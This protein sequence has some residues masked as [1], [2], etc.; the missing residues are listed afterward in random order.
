[1]AS[2]VASFTGTTTAGSATQASQ[3]GDIFIACAF[4]DGSATPPATPAGWIHHS[5][6]AG[7]S[8]ALLLVYIVA[9]G[10]TTA[11]NG[12]FTN[13]ASLTI[14]QVRAGG[15]N[16]L[17]LGGFA[18]SAGV[19][20]ATSYPA[21]TSINGGV[22]SDYIAAA[23]HRSTNT[24]VNTAP[25]GM[26]NITSVVGASESAVHWTD[27]PIASWAGGAGPGGGTSSGWASCALELLEF[28]PT[29]SPITVDDSVLRVVETD[30]SVTT[31]SFTAPAG[32]LLVA[33][34]KADANDGL[35]TYNYSD[36][37]GLTW[38]EHVKQQAAGSGS[39]AIATAVTTSAV[40]RTV[41]VSRTGATTGDLAIK[42]FIV[43]GQDA[44]DPIGQTAQGA[45]AV[46]HIQP[47]LFTSGADDAYVFVAAT[48][49]QD[50]GAPASGDLEADNFNGATISFLTGYRYLGAIGAKGITLNA[51]STGTPDWDWAALE[52]LPSTGAAA[53]DIT[54]VLFDDAD[55]FG[56]ATVS[57]SYT[58]TGTL[59][60]DADSFGTAS[61]AATFTIGG[62]L[63]S[64]ADAFGVASITQD[65]GPQ[66]ITGAL[67][68]D[69]DTFGSAGLAGSYSVVGQLFA[70]GD[71]FG[72]AT[73][74]RGAVTVSGALFADADTFGA[75]IISISGGPQSI[76][77]SLFS[78]P[79]SF[80]TAVLGGTFTVQGA[81]FSDPDSFGASTVSPGAFAILAALFSNQN[82]F[83]T[84]TLTGGDPPV[85]G[86]GSGGFLR[87]RRR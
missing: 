1:M 77:A 59:F 81:L 2:I 21:V 17:R 3:A 64:D 28:D 23:G 86:E 85:I 68:V 30:A 84:A 4:R 57:A 19:S 75:A 65:A 51:A 76:N 56:A 7:T 10:A 69:P 6:H 44:V 79:D 66:A 54:G 24:N 34:M 46:N 55:S 11:I 9:T 31:A 87:R 48:E 35:I 38:T 5:I 45:S 70:D 82:T 20:A 43:T 60:A 47:A 13:S 73:I 83:H 67:F 63:F 33:V 26:T 37:G 15:S 78:N 61:I 80:G 40:A 32:A 50:L 36:S 53:Q 39:A 16:V 58:I 71:A 42:V 29:V 52:I 74:A 49:W 14:I 62:V 8:C 72:A 41:T 12:T 25:S 22:N 27:G 18:S